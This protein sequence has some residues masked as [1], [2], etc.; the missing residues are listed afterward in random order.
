MKMR[1]VITKLTSGEEVARQVVPHM[2]ALGQA[3]GARA[4]RIVP[5]RTYALNDSIATE[6]KRTGAKVTT[7]VTAGGGDVDYALYVERGTSIM[8]A[9]PYLRPALLQSRAADLNYSG[10]G[11]EK[12]GVRRERMKSSRVARDRRIADRRKGES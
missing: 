6:T 2:E 9:Q 5:K 11:I 1:L 12:R 7:R 4:Q 3:I 8:A 10:A